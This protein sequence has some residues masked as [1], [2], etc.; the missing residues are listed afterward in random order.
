M[1]R[2][3]ADAFNLKHTLESGQIFRF[4]EI[5]GWYY[6]NA[7]DKYFKI[8]QMKNEIEFQ[9]VNQEFIIYFFSLDEN[10]TK[11]LEEINKDP[12]IH[13]AIE[14]YHG[15]RLIRQDPW[16]CLV[17][18]ICSS[19]SN[20]P[21]IKSKLNSLSRLFGKKQ[22]LGECSSFTFPL[23]GEIDDYAKIKEAKT[24][25][26]AKYIF[27]T[28]KA[29]DYVRLNSLRETSYQSAKDELKTFTGIGDKVADCILL[30]SLGFYQA[31]PVDT[32]IKKTIQQHYFNNKSVPNKTIR[33]FGM[34]YFGRYAG[35][36]QQ[37]LFVF[38]RMKSNA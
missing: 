29:I 15:L 1:G 8:K 21:R 10:Y 5:N 13:K 36:A 19:A 23:P 7:R 4:N 28:N 3:I 11:I 38:S 17:A 37:Y 35:Y 6:I 26:R 24:G 32:W 20:I 31:F 14:Q 22:W 33:E 18:F 9:G 30:F 27:E 16:E 2:I 12:F 25:F 34:D